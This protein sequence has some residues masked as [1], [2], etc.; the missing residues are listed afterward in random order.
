MAI[1]IIIVL[2]SFAL[3]YLLGRLHQIDNRN[4]GV[5]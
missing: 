5:T 4:G 2:I 3:G 1:E